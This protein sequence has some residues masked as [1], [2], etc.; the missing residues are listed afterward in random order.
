MDK[1]FVPSNI[2]A[3]ALRALDPIQKRLGL[4]DKQLS[5]RIGVAECSVGRWRRG[6]AMS[7]ASA[8]KVSRFLLDPRNKSA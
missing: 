8:A 7:R 4:N 1:G 3:Q 2:Q 5:A 6:V